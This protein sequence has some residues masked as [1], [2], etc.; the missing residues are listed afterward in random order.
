M[1]RCLWCEVYFVSFLER[2]VRVV[3][4]F[5]EFLFLIGILRFGLSCFLSGFLRIRCF[6]FVL[7]G[8]GCCRYWL[9]CFW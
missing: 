2:N 5:V 1:V 4:I 8:E 9:F 6:W 3:L 7:C